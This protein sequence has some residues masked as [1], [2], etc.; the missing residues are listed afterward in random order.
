M[1]LKRKL[2]GLIKKKAKEQLG[3]KFDIRDF[4]DTVLR[5]GAL[6]LNELEIL[7]DTYILDNK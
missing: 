7:V 1:E 2:P 6:P 4:H 3:T 5:E